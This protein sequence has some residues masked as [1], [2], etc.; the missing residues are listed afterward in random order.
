MRFLISVLPA[1]LARFGIRYPD[2]VLLLGFSV[3][4]FWLSLLLATLAVFS[5]RLSLSSGFISCRR[6]HS[7]GI[8]AE[9]RPALEPAWRII[10]GF[11]CLF[12]CF[13][14]FG[15]AALLWCAS[16]GAPPLRRL[17]RGGIPGLRALHSG[18]FWS[19]YACS[20][21]LRCFAGLSDALGA[22]WWRPLAKRCGA[23]RSPDLTAVAARRCLLVPL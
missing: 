4:S 23:A 9:R 11:L 13:L 10:C 15:A 8:A 5:P 16:G 18:A 12:P 17:L 6:R 19:F 20:G 14:P 21:C 22:R 7:G 1:F 3:W 2:P